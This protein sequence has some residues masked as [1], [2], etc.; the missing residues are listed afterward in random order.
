MTSIPAIAPGSIVVGA[1]GSRH[2]A[3]ALRWA[4]AQARREHRPLVVVTAGGG[5]AD[6]VNRDALVAVRELEPT[7]DAS[8]VSV[9]LDPRPALVDLSRDAHLVVVGSH[10]R[11]FLR[12]VLLGSVGTALTRLSWCPVVVCRPRDEERGGRGVLVAVDAT[13]S[14][15]PVLEFAFQQASL[16]GEPL[17]AVHCTWDVVAAVAGLRNVRLEDDDLGVGD[18]AHLALAEALAG[19]AETYPDVEVSQRVHHGLVDD[20]VGRH[21]GDWDLVVVGRH[22]VDT[23]GRLVTGSIATAVVERARTTV[24]VV[25]VERDPDDAAALGED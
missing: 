13:S 6:R 18:E 11:G 7:V 9:D 16:R 21:T 5:D 25:P 10:G 4:A 24:A 20:V 19:F 2:A 12:S 22:P 8:G 1:D 14:S 3:R 15:S 23:L 17:T